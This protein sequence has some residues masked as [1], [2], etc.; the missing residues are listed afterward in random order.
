M[1]QWY[2]STLEQH[3]SENIKHAICQYIDGT[4]EHYHAERSQPGERQYKSDR[5]CM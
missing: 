1:L 4:T 2:I 3:S 5:L